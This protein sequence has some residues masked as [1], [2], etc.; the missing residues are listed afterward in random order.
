MSFEYQFAIADPADGSRIFRRLIRLEKCGNFIAA[1]LED[2]MHACKLV[3]D[4]EGDT[5][6]ACT[7]AAIEGSLM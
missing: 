6:A 2:I 5:S 4:I 7:I 1:G 3:L